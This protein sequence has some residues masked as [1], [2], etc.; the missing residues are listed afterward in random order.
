MRG[1]LELAKPRIAL[2]SA[3]TALAGYWLAGGRDWVQAGWLAAGTLLA[4]CSTGTLNQC[5]EVG[6]DSRM[7]LT[8]R[9][10]LP[11]GRVSLARAAAF[12]IFCGA[13]GLWILFAGSGSLAC[14]L[15]F[16][17][18][19]GYVFAY[20]PLKLVTPQ[21]TWIGAVCGAMPPL[22]GWAAATGSLSAA[23]WS[24]FAIQFLWQIPHFLAL[25]WLHREDYIRAG[26][27]VM[28]AIDQDGSATALQ[29]AVHSLTLCLA[30]LL[31]LLIGMA[32]FATASA[33]WSWARVSRCWGSRR[34]GPCPTPTRAG[35]SSPLSSTCRRSTG[36]S[37]YF[38][39]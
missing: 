22:I 11:E 7:E 18:L 14:A 32:G 34:A 37:R 8:R 26:F 15:A 35:S 20:T 31:P 39:S 16:A 1:F 38:I 13:A 2:M 21:S 23:A 10:P 24:L 4:A 19:A 33:P 36:C 27:Q 28:P 30:G 29:I 6:P 5:L 3:L 12:G 25:F 9:R 17:T